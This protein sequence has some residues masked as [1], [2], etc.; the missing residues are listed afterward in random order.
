MIAET[1]II[2]E[3][4]EKVTGGEKIEFSAFRK[5]ENIRKAI[6]YIIPG[7]KKLIT[8]DKAFLNQPLWDVGANHVHCYVIN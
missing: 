3:M 4:S 6:G 7:Y 2:A 5:H 1:A 8:M